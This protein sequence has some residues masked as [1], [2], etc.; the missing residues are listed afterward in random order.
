MIKWISLKN[1]FIIIALVGA[2]QLSI[3]GASLT[4]PPHELNELDNPLCGN[5]TEDASLDLN[6]SE[7]STVTDVAIMSSTLSEPPG[8]NGSLEISFGTPPGTAILE[9]LMRCQ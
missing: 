1:I 4:S 8:L 7:N 6:R 2:L 9:R 3:A 5:C